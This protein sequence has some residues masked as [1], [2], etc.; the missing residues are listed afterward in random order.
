MREAVARG[1]MLA[2]VV[3]AFAWGGIQEF[4]GWSAP[5]WLDTPAPFGFY[6]LLHLALDRWAWR[7][8]RIGAVLRVPDLRGNWLGVV[9]TSHDGFQVEHAVTI[10]VRQSWSGI[11]IRLEGSSSTSYSVSAN[12][13]EGSGSEAFELTYQY[14]NNPRPGAASTMHAHQGTAHLRLSDDGRVLEGEYY[15]GRDRQNHGSLRVER[16]TR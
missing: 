14:V 15:S 13:Y 4:S 2:G 9:R 5:W 16:A 7:Q 6:S 3:L 10:V 12:I 1:L 11:L 8:P